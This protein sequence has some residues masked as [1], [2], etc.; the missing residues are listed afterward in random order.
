M[1][2]NHGYSLL[3][4]SSNRWQLFIYQSINWCCP[5]ISFRTHENLVRLAVAGCLFKS[6]LLTDLSVWFRS[7][8][9]YLWLSIKIPQPILFCMCHTPQIYPQNGSLLLAHVYLFLHNW[10]KAKV[11]ANHNEKVRVC[12]KE[13][14]AKEE[15]KVVKVILVWMN[16]DGWVGGSL[17]IRSGQLREG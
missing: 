16:N 8:K 4:I 13:V 9:A 5:H 14:Q 2:I 3:L 17:W 12:R 7:K 15:Y 10:Y 6:L 1:D 11:W